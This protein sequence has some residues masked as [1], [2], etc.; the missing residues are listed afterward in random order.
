[1]SDRKR[2][3]SFSSTPIDGSPNNKGR[4]ERLVSRGRDHAMVG[5][6]FVSCSQAILAALVEKVSNK[7]CQFYMAFKNTEEGNECGQGGFIQEERLAAT[8]PVDANTNRKKRHKPTRNVLFSEYASFASMP[9][10][11]KHNLDSCDDE[12]YL[13]T[14]VKFVTGHE[15]DV[16]MPDGGCVLVGGD[17][18]KSFPVERNLK[19]ELR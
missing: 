19:S 5:T 12:E 8:P 11:A 14:T 7:A 6:S 9:V 3:D 4:G 2:A 18:L 15:T 1:M 10:T 16:A 17:V 13:R